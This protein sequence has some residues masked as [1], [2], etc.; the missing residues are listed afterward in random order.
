MREYGISLFS[1]YR[2]SAIEFKAGNWVEFFFALPHLKPM[3][4]IA[5]VFLCSVLSA[6]A[7]LPFDLPLKELLDKKVY[8]APATYPVPEKDEGEIKAIFYEALSYKGKATRAF[9]Y[10]G[11]PKGNK[12]VPAIVCVHGGGGTAFHEWVKIWNDRGYAAIS[13]SLEGHMPSEK[14]HKTKH[15]FSGPK[16]KGRFD[17][18]KEPLNEQW[19]Y[20][21][22]SNVMLAHSLLRSMPEIDNDRI[23]VTGI[24]WGGILTSLISGVDDRFQCAIPVYGAGFLEK[25]LGHFSSVN[26]VQNFWDPSRQFQYGAMPTLWVNGDADGHFSVNITS[27]SYLATKERSWVTITPG[28]PHGHKSGWDS[29]Q[30]PE[31]Y[32]FADHILKNEEACLARLTNT[33][34]SDTVEFSYESKLSLVSAELYFT[35]EFV[36]SKEE[37]AKHPAPKT[38]QKMDAVLNMDKNVITAELPS[39]AKVYYLNVINKDGLTSSSALMSRD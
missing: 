18:I 14:S 21:A 38:W 36:Y 4:A 34:N 6:V 24:S 33:K 7:E 16:R 13:M 11:I 3:K 1:C 10:Y 39:E 23:G 25:S 22:V 9:A 2:S 32:A 15:E 8:K 20:H 31:I 35:D 26:G 27:E 28:L 5:L 12:P 29:K 30:V 19:M 17:D 37:G